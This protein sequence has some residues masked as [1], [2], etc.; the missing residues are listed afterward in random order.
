MFY[1]M[2]VCV[3]VCMSARTRAGDNGKTEGVDTAVTRLTRMPEVSGSEPSQS[4]PD[5]VT[6][7]TDWLTN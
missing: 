5:R 6:V 2:L 7:M 4:S 3:C 1:L